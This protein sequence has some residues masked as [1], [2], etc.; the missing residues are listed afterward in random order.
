MGLTIADIIVTSVSIILALVNFFFFNKTKT[1]Y[2]KITGYDLVSYKDRFHSLYSDI[3]QKIKRPN[4][5]RGGKNNDLLDNL[6]KALIDYNNCDFRIKDENQR[7]N[8]ESAISEIKRILPSFY[9][10]TENQT[11]KD[12]LSKKLDVIDK[13]LVKICDS[14]K[15]KN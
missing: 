11:D 12:N 9:T 6:D 13:E 14:V 15:A 4:W 10:G 3:S 2:N 5:N 8:I 7:Y 1:I